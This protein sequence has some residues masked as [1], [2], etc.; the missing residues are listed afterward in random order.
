MNT[1]EEKLQKDLVAAMKNKSESQV[2][3][4]RAVKTAIQNEKTN[5]AY[6]ELTDDDVL[7]II[8][9]QVKEREDSA[10]VYI[11]AKRIDLAEK[12]ILEAK[13]LKETYLPA[14]LSESDVRTAVEGIMN[15][16]GKNMGAIMKVLKEKYPNQVDGKQAS[17][18]IKEMLAQ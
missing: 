11:E 17:V 3:S 4:I 13:F 1:L 10:A 9:K 6:H 14:Q 8:R 18:I 7:K 5:G 15:D 12:E 2:V 16:V